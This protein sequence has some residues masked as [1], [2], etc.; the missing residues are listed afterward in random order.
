M[1]ASKKTG[2]KDTMSNLYD[3]TAKS[4]DREVRKLSEFGGKVCLLVNVA[5]ECGLTPQYDGLQRLYTEYRDQG[6]EILGFPCNQFGGQ[7][8]G[9]ESQIREFCRTNYGVGFPLFAKIEVNGAGRDPLYA[10]LAG[11]D[12]GPDGPGDIAWN[13]AKFLVDRDGNLI[14]RFA[15]TT[16]PCSAEIKSRLEE[17]LEGS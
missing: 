4:I 11:E 2:W 12:V 9:S 7:E 3:F 17:V 13:F 5:S 10:W 6:L 15:P 16:E 8:P 1:T 14:A